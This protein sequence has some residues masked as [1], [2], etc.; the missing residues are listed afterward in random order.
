MSLEHYSDSK[1]VFVPSTYQLID[2]NKLS[3]SWNTIRLVGYN[4]KDGW[5][6]SNWQQKIAAK[7]D[8]TLAYNRN[9]Y[10]IRPHKAVVQWVV[11]KTERSATRVDSMRTL[12]LNYSFTEDA[13]TR[14]TALKI[15]KSKFSESYQDFQALIPLAEIKETR[16]LIRTTADITERLLL[17][18]IAIKRGRGNLKRISQLASDAWL[19]YSFAISPTIGDIEQLLTVIGDHLTRNDKTFNISK[20]F[21]KRWTASSKV[22]SYSG[23]LPDMY[24]DYTTETFYDLGYRYTGGY[25]LNLSSGNDYHTYERFGLDFKQLPLVAWELIPFSWVWDYF[26]TMGQFLDDVFVAKPGQT[27]YLNLAK[28]YRITSIT[29]GVFRPSATNVKIW[30]QSFEPEIL[31]YFYF[32][33]TGLA[34]LPH[35]SLRFKTGDEISANFVRKLLNLSSV[36]VG[37][38]K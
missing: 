33:R 15:F 37:M 32:D 21:S 25:N 22:R 29:T 34:S 31:S 10:H 7:Q 27:V 23:Y 28:R 26:T 24:L 8:A 19:Q 16:G 2:N 5:R 30:H 12:P 18:L 1:A 3:S 36:L 9:F 38:R 11:G 20:G 6:D 35:R 4:T 17:E 13:V 14:D